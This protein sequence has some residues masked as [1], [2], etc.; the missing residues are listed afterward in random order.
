MGKS[1]TGTLGSWFETGA[2]G[3]CWVVY[4]D[5]EFEHSEE[6]YQGFVAI[7]HGDHLKVVAQDG[8]VVFDGVVRTDYREGWTKYPLNPGY[9]Q[10]AALGFWIHWTQHGWSAEKW[11]SLFG[12]KADGLVYR[13]ELTKCTDEERKTAPCPIPPPGVTEEEWGCDV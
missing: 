13:A 4:V 9:G 3:L 11:A 1:F 8:S 12:L 6:V 5:Q 2:E 10:P 7:D